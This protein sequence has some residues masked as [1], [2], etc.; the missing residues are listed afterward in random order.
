[1]TLKCMPMDFQNID[2]EFSKAVCLN[3]AAGLVVSEKYSE[4]NEAYKDARKH[5][6]SGIA[7]NHIKQLQSKE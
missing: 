6:L 1:M 5:I 2:N 4:F 3:A 7:Y